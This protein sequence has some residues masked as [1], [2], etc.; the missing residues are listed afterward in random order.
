MS[1]TIS[2][3][4]TPVNSDTQQATT[5]LW[6]VFV[7]LVGLNLRPFLTA[8]GTLAQ[9][10]AQSLQMPLGQ[11]A[12][13]TFIPMMIMGIGAFSLPSLRNWVDTRRLTLMALVCLFLGSALRLK[14][15]S[16]IELIMTAVLCGV[17]VAVLQTF[18]P[19]IIKQNF[20]RHVAPV[21]GLYS[22][23][24]MGGGAF[25]A[26]FTPLLSDLTDSWRWGLAFWALPVLLAV[27][28]AY[29]VLPVNKAVKTN[30]S[31]SLRSYLALPRTWALI[32]SFG[33]VNAGYATLITWLA[34]YYQGHGW[35]APAS[36]SLVAVLSIA[37]A[38]AALAIPSLAAKNKDRRP[39]L[40]LVLFCQFLGF[41]A[42]SYIPDTA[43]YLWAIILGVGLGGC[44]A[45]VM[46]VALD[47]YPDSQRA[48][49]LSALMQG[50][51]FPIA[52]LAPIIGSVIYQHTGSF[53]SLWLMHLC[54]IAFI[55]LLTYSFQPKHYAKVM[56]YE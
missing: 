23:T 52:A 55:A 41:L 13:L 14:V 19:G 38:A 46:V 33:L 37:Q 11:M 39:W 20:P 16:N 36:G 48:G 1:R 42:V 26:Q 45:M 22:A 25:G 29:R 51:G 15:D 6:L 27:W 50:G 30:S 56:R 3:S 40:W 5:R 54:F 18:L 35:S 12:W 32:A 4:S 8:S 34:V 28:V 21:T 44:F 24:L 2:T 53:H 49:V 10:I 47:H 17:G 7:I 9:E 31:L 43:P